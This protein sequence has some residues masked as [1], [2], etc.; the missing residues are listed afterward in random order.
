M[1]RGPGPT[2]EEVGRLIPKLTKPL[3]IRP[4]AEIDIADAALW[5]EGERQGLGV[6]FVNEVERVLGRIVENPLIFSEVDRNLRR[7]LLRR[8]PYG[9]YFALEESQ[10]TILSVLHFRR[11]PTTWEK[12]R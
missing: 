1:V 8:F 4:E 2:S 5:Y 9:I 3:V 11:D 12:R 6:D 10:T 7:A